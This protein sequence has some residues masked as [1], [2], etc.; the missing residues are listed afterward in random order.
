MVAFAVVTLMG[1]GRGPNPLQ[2]RDFLHVTD[3]EK[4]AL[5]VC[6]TLNPVTTPSARAA[7]YQARTV[8]VGAEEYPRTQLWS[9]AAYF[10][11]RRPHLPT[12]TEPYTGK[13]LGDQG[14]SFA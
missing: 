3:R 5:G 13:A 4:A 8:T 11:D 2:L 14:G 12:M 9:I 7:V 10:D 6:V 1:A